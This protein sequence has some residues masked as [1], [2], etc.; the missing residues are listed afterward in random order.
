MKVWS[1][2]FNIISV[3]VLIILG[4]SFV[5]TSRVLQRDFDQ[6]HYNYAVQQATEAM[7]R[8][9]LKAEDIGLDYVDMSYVSINASSA[10]DT[11]DRVICANYDMSPSK[12]NYDAI[13]NSISACAIAGFDGYY[14]LETSKSDPIRGNSRTV[15]G[16]EM[17]FGVKHPYLYESYNGNVYALDIYK[18]TYSFM[19]ATSPNNKP[20]MYIIG[21]VY[22]PGLSKE[23]AEKL[24]SKQV[25][26]SILAE[27]RN[28]DRIED[29]EIEQFRLYF[30]EE[31]TVTGVNPFDAPGIILMMGFSNFASVNNITAQSVSGYKAVGITRVVAFKDNVTGRLYY[32]Y[33]GQLKDE[34]KDSAS[35]GVVV[36]GKQGIFHIENYYS[37]IKEAAE[38]VGQD[39]FTHY[40]P[41]YDILA[42]KITKE[43][44]S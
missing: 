41:Y 1:P 29:F 14:I 23:T 18:K 42:R 36:G 9:T 33:E 21:A 31:T 6:E 19:S 30:P 27:M 22:P 11:F 4:L 40:A 28:T 34:E 44:A 5:N 16:Y 26:D 38:A 32:C 10:L 17:K 12:E 37:T 39:G 25:R 8:S 3:A 20:T 2:I 7:F 43:E 13:N 35:G 15:D 24:V